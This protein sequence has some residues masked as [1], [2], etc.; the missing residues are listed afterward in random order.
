[1]NALNWIFRLFYNYILWVY[2]CKY[3]S[4]KKKAQSLPGQLVGKQYNRNIVYCKYTK[5]YNKEWNIY[6]NKE[7]NLTCYEIMYLNSRSNTYNEL[8]L[9]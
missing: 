7:E 8:F 5:I 2:Y 4:P 3:N 9:R 6:N 1:M